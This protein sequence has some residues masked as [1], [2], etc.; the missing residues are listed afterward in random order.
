M[1]TLRANS[2]IP[3]KSNIE[4]LLCETNICKVICNITY[5][6]LKNNSRQ[7]ELLKEVQSYYKKTCDDNSEKM[8][9]GR[10]WLLVKKYDDSF[11]VLQVAQALDYVSNERKGFFYEIYSH[12]KEMYGDIED[13]IYSGFARK[14]EKNGILSFYELNIEAYL[15]KFA[16]SNYK[17]IIYRM[18]REYFAEAS[19]AYFTQAREWGF[20]NSGMDKRA[21]YYLC[22]NIKSVDIDKQNE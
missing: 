6:D 14:L 4:K 13:N 12:V 9:S 20:Y 22:E 16:P 8:Q 18:A 21:L 10:V 19:I 1:G 5:D 3:Q 17:E 15:E 2:S 7:D 11:E